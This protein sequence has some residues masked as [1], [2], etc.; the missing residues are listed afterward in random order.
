MVQFTGAPGLAEK[1][2]NKAF[3][4]LRSAA[5]E[6]KRF[7]FVTPTKRTVPVFIAR[8]K[9]PAQVKT[10]L[11]CRRML[12]TVKKLYPSR[13]WYAI[14]HEGMISSNWT[15][16]LKL[17]ANEGTAPT[18]IRFNNPG[19]AELEISRQDVEEA[20]AKLDKSSLEEVAWSL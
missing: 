18:T 4:C 13:E 15:P 2:C 20:F 7:E 1:R 10:E 11:A 6:W 8:D 19:C 9:N 5:G 12:D 16:L 3:E 14:K 17:A